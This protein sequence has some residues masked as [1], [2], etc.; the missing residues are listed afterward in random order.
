LVFAGARTGASFGGFP[1]VFAP[2]PFLL[3]SSIG[4]WSLETDSE[5]VMSPIL[6]PGDER[7]EYTDWELQA[8]GD[9]GYDVVAC[10]D[11]FIAGAEECDDENADEEDGC[12]SSCRFVPEPV[13]EPEP[14]PVPEP[15]PEPEPEP[16]PVPE[17]VPEPQ[18]EPVADA[19]VPDAMVVEEERSPP[20]VLEEGDEPPA[21]SSSLQPS[22]GCNVQRSQGGGGSLTLV[23][24]LL[25]VLRR[26]AFSRPSRW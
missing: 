16:E 5:A 11:G 4:H 7:R 26:P 25:A 13:P 8:L 21:I 14:E 6:E 17:P 24:L 1:A 22:G 19:G 9:L 20:T 3:G 2:N 10:G 18:P 12:D 23:L 15:Q